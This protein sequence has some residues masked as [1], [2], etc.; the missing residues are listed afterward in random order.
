MLAAKLLYPRDK[1]SIC[2]QQNFYKLMT[3]LLYPL[4]K[5]SI[6]SRYNFNILA[7]KLARARY[8]FPLVFRA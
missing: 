4:S 8:I 3:K 7:T 6:C 2:S 1:T 5:T